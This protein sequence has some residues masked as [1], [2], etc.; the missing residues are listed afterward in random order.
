MS[1]HLLALLLLGCDLLLQR[2][3]H[4][5]VG[6]GTHHL[7]TLLPSNQVSMLWSAEGEGKKNRLVVKFPEDG[8]CICYS[9]YIE[10][11]N[12]LPFS[13]AVKGW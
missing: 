4:P 11:N 9:S 1:A 10:K 2:G 5:L 13:G 12:L 7:V 6:L 3:H 8:S